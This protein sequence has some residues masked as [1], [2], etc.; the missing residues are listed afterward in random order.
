MLIIKG[1][2][3][4]RPILCCRDCMT[5]VFKIPD[6]TDTSE[7]VVDTLINKAMPIHPQLK[8]QSGDQCIC[9]TCGSSWNV[10]MGMP[11]FVIEEG[12]IEGET[13]SKKNE[14]E[15]ITMTV[16]SKETEDRIRD[17]FR[18]ELAAAKSETVVVQ[19]GEKEIGRA[20]LGSV[21][22]TERSAN[23]PLTF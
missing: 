8:P 14:Q 3:Y 17:I 9:A 16:L 5:P 20:I 21:K 23:S 11:F 6:D 7:R 19:M 13:T 18:E 12:V 22:K 15:G 10:L 1:Q 4:E 2:S